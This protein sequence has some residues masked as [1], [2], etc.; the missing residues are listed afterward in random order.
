MVLFDGYVNMNVLYPRNELVNVIF[1]FYNDAYII[2]IFLNIW[3]NAHFVSISDNE[4][5]IGKSQVLPFRK[6]IYMYFVKIKIWNKYSALYVFVH[7]VSTTL[8][9]TYCPTNIS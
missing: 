2:A 5:K 6:K 3:F 9:A 1:N 4:K 7:Y 8:T